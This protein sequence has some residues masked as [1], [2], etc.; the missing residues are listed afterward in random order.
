[1]IRFIFLVGCLILMTPV[2]MLGQTAEQEDIQFLII[3]ALTNNP[4]I[5]AELS[6]MDMLDQRITQA[7]ALDDPELR[8]KLMEMPGFKPSEAMYANLELMQ[9]IRFPTKLST[10]SDIASVQAEHA[11]HDHLHVVLGVIAE[12]KSAYA[13]LWYARTAFALTQENQR[14]VEQI[15]RTAQTRYAVGSSSQQD[16]LKTNIELARLKTKEASLKQEIIAAESMLRSILNR[17]ATSPVGGIEMGPLPEVN[18]SLDDLLSFGLANK[19]MLVHDSLTV[20]ESDLMLNLSRQEYLP[21]FNLSLEYVTSPLLGHKQ[22]SV[23]VGI[24]LP[25]APWTLGKASARVQEAQAGRAMSASKFQSAKN[26]TYAKIQEN[27]EAVRAYETEV[28]YYEQ[29]ILP[30]TKQSLQALMAEYQTGTTSYLMLLDT[31]RMYQEMSMDAAMA[32]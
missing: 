28:K 4:D 12:L 31:Y 25:F 26:M 6:R 9:M 15:L 3:E 21:D 20:R 19:P 24:T 27:Y 14:L 11:H 1:M 29:T 16:V 17:P 18:Q 13:M 32:R 8:F 30:Q 10:Q 22:W 23:M 2:I 7:G 5:A